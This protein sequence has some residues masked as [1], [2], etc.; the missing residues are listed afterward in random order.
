LRIGTRV[1]SK[2]LAREG[3]DVNLFGLFVDALL[4]EL[5]GDLG[6]APQLALFFEARNQVVEA[7]INRLVAGEEDRA[8]MVF[9][10][11]KG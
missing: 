2:D 5:D 9:L 11:D 10:F 4:A 7:L 8:K 3:A 6:L 1:V